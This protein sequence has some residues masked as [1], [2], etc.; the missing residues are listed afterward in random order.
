MGQLVHQFWHGASEELI[1]ARFT[2]G[3]KA[4]KCVI[5]DPP[6]GVNNMSRQAVTHEGKQAARKIANDETPEIAMNTFVTVFNQ[7]IPHTADDC[8][9]YVFTSYQVLQEWIAF[10]D[11]CGPAYGWV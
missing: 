5:T 9:F 2:P 1:P 3:R 7:L 8:D 6:F 11:Q 4:I 10:L